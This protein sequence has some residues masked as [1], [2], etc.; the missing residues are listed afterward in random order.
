[1]TLDVVDINDGLDGHVVLE[2]EYLDRLY[3]NCYVPN[4]HAGG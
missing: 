2:L 3:V 4:L 1:M